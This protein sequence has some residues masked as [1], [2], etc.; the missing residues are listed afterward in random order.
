MAYALS[1]PYSEMHALVSSFVDTL[2]LL[3]ELLLLVVSAFDTWMSFPLDGLLVTNHA[4][5]RPIELAVLCWQQTL[6]F[7]TF[8][9]PV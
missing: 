4:S 3:S 2:A 6:T 8:D 7:G 5:G 9:T 1:K